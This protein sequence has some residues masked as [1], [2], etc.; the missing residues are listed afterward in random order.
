MKTSQS[1]FWTTL[2]REKTVLLILYNF[3]VF[4]Q[5]KYFYFG[6]TSEKGRKVVLILYSVHSV[7]STIDFVF[8]LTILKIYILEPPL[9]ISGKLIYSIRG[10]QKLNS[11]HKMWIIQNLGVHC[12]TVGNFFLNFSNMLRKTQGSKVRFS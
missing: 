9:V 2:V 12:I 3:L 6:A 11:S 8:V 1:P 5:N 4:L 10:S 7:Y